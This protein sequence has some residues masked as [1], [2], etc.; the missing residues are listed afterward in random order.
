MDRI[1]HSEATMSST[2]QP[3][4][5]WWP[6]NRK[7]NCM[8]I[9]WNVAPSF[10]KHANCYLQ[11]GIY[12]VEDLIYQRMRGLANRGL[13]MLEILLRSSGLHIPSQAIFSFSP[14]G[15]SIRAQYDP[16]V[17]N[18]C[19]PMTLWCIISVG[20]YYF[21]TQKF[22]SAQKN[23]NSTHCDIWEIGS[24]WHENSSYS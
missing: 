10:M 7:S 1:P 19:A 21:H 9:S 15:C 23:H 22:S 17:L 13:L 11:W 6:R 3:M 2:Q 8:L 18:I 12:E 16:L 20:S 5:G 14:V 24:G 4:A